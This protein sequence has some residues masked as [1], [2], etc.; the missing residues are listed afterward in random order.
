MRIKQD[1]HQH[2]AWNMVSSS[3][4]VAPAP[5][6][7]QEPGAVGILARLLPGVDGVGAPGDAPP[8]SGC[9]LLEFLQPSADLGS[10]TRHRS[11][12]SLFL[13]RCKALRTS[14]L[15]VCCNI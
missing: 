4:V 3:T 2:C 8:A 5:E 14:I 11:S 12:S 10:W 9:Q 13:P 6:G 7:W 15:C 1:N